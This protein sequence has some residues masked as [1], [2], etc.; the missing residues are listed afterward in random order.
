MEAKKVKLISFAY[1]NGKISN[2]SFTRVHDA[3]K[4]VRN[5]W[6]HPKLRKLNGLD[7]DVQA[8]VTKCAGAQV[9]INKAMTQLS[10]GFYTAAIGCQGGKH[11]SVAIVEIIAQQCR[12]NGWDVE[13]EHRDLKKK[14]KVNGSQPA[15]ASPTLEEVSA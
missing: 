2:S 1:K 10:L 9:I 3:R 13:I 15:N 5:P 11:R 14:E 7:S 6:R 8:F 4:T 12:E